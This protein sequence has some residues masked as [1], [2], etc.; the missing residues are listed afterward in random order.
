[1]IGFIFLLT[2]SQKVSSVNDL[3]LIEGKFKSITQELNKGSKYKRV[4]Y[5]SMDTLT[6][7][8]LQPFNSKFQISYSVY[9]QERFIRTI[10]VGE[11]ISIHIHKEDLN[12]LNKNEKIRGFS[13]KVNNLTYLKPEHAVRGLKGG[14]RLFLILVVVILAVTIRFIFTNYNKWR[15]KPNFNSKS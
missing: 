7:I 10:K 2:I 12:R 4:K 9:D 14:N 3:A 15:E 1:M 5:S 6:F 11:K 8:H 13:L